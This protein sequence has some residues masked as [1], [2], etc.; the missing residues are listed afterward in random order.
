M[1]LT[2]FTEEVDSVRQLSFLQL[3]LALLDELQQLL[4]PE[5]GE[6]WGNPGS[7][8]QNTALQLHVAFWNQLA[9]HR[10]ALDL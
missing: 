8:L 10:L 5:N 4:V 6:L 9:H 7:L 2:G 1:F 3:Q